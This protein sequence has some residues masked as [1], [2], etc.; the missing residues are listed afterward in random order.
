VPTFTTSNTGTFD[1]TVPYMN[2]NKNVGVY[3]VKIK[4]SIYVPNDATKAAFT[5]VVVEYTFQIYISP[6]AINSYTETSAV[7]A[8]TYTVGAPMLTSPSYVF[9][10]NPVCNY[11]ETVTVTDLPSFMTHD[12]ASAKFTIP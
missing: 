4:N 1:F 5:P 3:S 11:P 7:G 6:C 12:I 10:E 2:T 8:I 9:D